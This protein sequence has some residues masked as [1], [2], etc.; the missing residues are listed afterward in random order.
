MTEA[1]MPASESCRIAS[2]RLVGVDARGS[3]VLAS[4]RSIVVTDSATLASPRSAM[5]ARFSRARGS[6]A[7]FLARVFSGNRA[8]ADGLVISKR[9]AAS[10]SKNAGSAEA[11]ARGLATKK[12]EAEIW[13][14]P[15]K[16]QPRAPK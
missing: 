9:Q 10:L 6:R 11:L 8:L 7:P 16:Q 4:M 13:V 2:S 5:A 3:I 1:G 14:A 12:L 15:P